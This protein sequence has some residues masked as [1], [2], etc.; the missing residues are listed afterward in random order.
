MTFQNPQWLWLLC[1]LPLIALLRSRRGPRASIRFSSV[2]AA[3]ELARSSRSRIGGLLLALRLLAAAAFIVAL[4]R[5][6]IVDAK[7]RVKASGTDLVLAVDVSTSMDALDMTLHD[8]PDN[9][10][11]AVKSV[12]ERFIADR[13][14]DRIGLIAFAGAP[15][16]LSPPTLDHDWLLRNLDRLHTGM[17]QDGTAIGSA[18]IASVNRLRHED[19]KSKSVIVLTDGMNNAGKVQ[20][21]LAAQAAAAEGVKVYTIGVG[22]N[23]QAMVP[24]TDDGGRRRMVMSE[25][26]VDEPTL[27]KIADTTGGRFFRATDT[28]SLRRVYADIDSMEKTTRSIDSRVTRRERFQ[29]PVS[30]GLLL[31]GLNLLGGTLLRPRVP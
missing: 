4:A 26:D 19:A 2:A 18:L 5:P 10:L 14:N 25:V 23:G 3:R 13:P 9:R 12:V 6:Q 8:K 24:V 11:D 1:A 15:Y 22:S 17:V 30:I 28:E 29:W 27:R 16:L 7:T 20:P 31:L 21:S